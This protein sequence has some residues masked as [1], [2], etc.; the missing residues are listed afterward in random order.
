MSNTQWVNDFFLGLGAWNLGL[1]AL[2]IYE[3]IC[4]T[5]VNHLHY[6]LPI[7]AVVINL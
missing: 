7:H 2:F 6:I 4:V 3:F 1:G 5:S